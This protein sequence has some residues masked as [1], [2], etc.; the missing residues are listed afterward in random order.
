[1]AYDIND[2]SPRDQYTAAASQ[3]VFTVSFEFLADA[4]LKVYQTLSGA[5]PDDA[6]NLL[7]LT[8]EY[9]VVGAGSNGTKEITLVT[10]AAAGDVITIMRDAGVDR[11]T[12]FLSNGD[13]DIASMNQELN[14]IITLVQQVEMNQEQRS[15]MFMRAA[16]LAGVSLELPAPAADSALVW[17]SAGTAY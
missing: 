14:K 10:G 15:L 13:L 4:D 1:M 9:T 6:A 2:T 12:E 7:T 8:T 5:D 17:N 3:A 11:D 16:Q